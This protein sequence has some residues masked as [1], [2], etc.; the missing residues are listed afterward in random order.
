MWEEMQYRL[1][2]T[3]VHNVDAIVWRVACRKV[4]Q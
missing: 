3:K 2:Q 4:Y 1:Y